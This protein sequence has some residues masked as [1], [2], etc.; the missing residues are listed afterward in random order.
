MIKRC[1]RCI[2]PE[3][4]PNITFTNDDVCNYC[5]AFERTDKK[6]D[7]NFDGKKVIFEKLI[8]QAKAH[9]Y[10]NN[11]KYDV[12]VPV[13]G[14]RDSSYIAWKLYNDYGLRVLCVNYANPF[15]SI[16]AKKNVRHVAS[17]IKS[18]VISFLYPN[19]RH[20]RTFR[21]NLKAWITR[22]HLATLGMVCI[23]CKP[24]YLEIYRIAQKNKISLIVDGAN[25]FE[26]TTFKMEAQAGVKARNLLSM[27]AIIN[28]FKKIAVNIDYLQ[29]VNFIPIIQTL[30]SL[31]GSTPFL[32]RRY[33]NITR[34]SYF[35]SFP[36]NEVEIN[37]TLRKIGWKKAEDN[38]SPWRFD[39]EIDSVKNY[40]YEKIINATEK[41]DL[42]SKNIRYGLMTRAEAMDRLGE[43]EIN[44]ELVDKILSQSGINR[45]DLDAA[46]LKAKSK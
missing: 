27:K 7:F 15:S 1:S 3:T 28:F 13:S 37:E 30:L 40:I 18:D 38:K 23:A 21:H 34:K 17:V 22:P 36:Y 19:Q 35:Y 29:P 14:G 4:I 24:I 20:Q 5:D 16:Q 8:N 46:C 39:C 42:F 9:A 25:V 43:A 33:P 10:K 2:L 41:D 11:S 12:L 6:Q 45:K 32:D 26:V 44:L 31:H